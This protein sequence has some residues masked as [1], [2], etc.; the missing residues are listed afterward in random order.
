MD[1][2]LK[3]LNVILVFKRFEKFGYS[4]GMDENIDG[5][6]NCMYVMM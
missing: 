4:I 1:L 2:I 3:I 6:G 5:C